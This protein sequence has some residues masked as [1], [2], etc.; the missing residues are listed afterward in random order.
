MSYK[1]ITAFARRGYKINSDIGDASIDGTP[2]YVIGESKF[3]VPELRIKLYLILYEERE[4]TDLPRVI[5]GHRIV[6]Q[7]KSSARV[8]LSKEQIDYLDQPAIT[9]IFNLY[10]RKD[11]QE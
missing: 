3:F 8:G 5:A 4:F 1:M 7:K 11:V 9:N 6:I 2:F 10:T